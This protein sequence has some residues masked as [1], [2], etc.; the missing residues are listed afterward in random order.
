MANTG[1]YARA[2][3]D[4][5][6]LKFYVDAPVDKQSPKVETYEAFWLQQLPLPTIG[7]YANHRISDHWSVNT[8]AY[9]TYFPVTETWMKEGGSVHLQQTNFDAKMNVVYSLKFLSV[10]PGIWFRHF[11]LKE[12]S[13]ED[14][15]EFLLNG[16]G[17]SMALSVHF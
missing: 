10:T 12:K 8:E 16:V 4:Y 1:I 9:G 17:Y 14:E 3:I 2:A 7:L 15:N 11:R 13:L 5:E 6:R